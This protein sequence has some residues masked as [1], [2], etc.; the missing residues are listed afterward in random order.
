MFMWRWLSRGVHLFLFFS[1]FL[2]FLFT[3]ICSSHS[4]LQCTREC[5]HV[6][7]H[8]RPPAVPPIEASAAG[9][10]E[11]G[12]VFLRAQTCGFHASLLVCVCPLMS[13][14]GLS[15]FGAVGSL[16]EFT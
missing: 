11:H 16:Q 9:K 7:T 2:L 14:L 8:A 4:P 3:L 15:G 13:A 5:T 10:S 6:R 12:A 1:P